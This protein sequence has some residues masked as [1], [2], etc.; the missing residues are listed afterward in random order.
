MFV[1]NI[2]QFKKINVLVIYI[3]KRL[4]EGEAI[5]LDLTNKGTTVV[6]E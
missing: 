4:D 5:E 6:Q 1:L 2:Q 3:D